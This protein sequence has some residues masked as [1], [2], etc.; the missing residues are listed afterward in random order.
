[1]LDIDEMLKDVVSRVNTETGMDL[2]FQLKRHS[3]SVTSEIYT[4][5]TDEK[6]RV[7]NRAMGEYEIYSIPLPID[8]S[9]SYQD[10]ISKYLSL[11]IER[12]LGS[13]SNKSRV[14]IVGLG[15]RHISSDSLGAKVCGKIGITIDNNN[16]PK[17]MAICP[18]VLGLTGIETYDII[19]GVIE[20]VKP[21]HLILIDS[22]CAS[23]V[24]RLGTSIQLS[25]TGLCPGRGIGNNR[26]CI[27]KSLCKN[28]VSIGVPL[29]IFASTFIRD[30]FNKNNIDFD[31]VADIMQNNEIVSNNE[32]FLKFFESI[33]SVYNDD[34]DGAIVTHKDIDK[35]VVNLAEIIAMAINKSLGV[36]ELIDG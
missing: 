31:V 19:S 17:V 22:L 26:R 15:N 13:I 32:D 14:L 2:P 4:I 23:S 30:T 25:N 35:M 20:K 3:E 21:T 11:S 27:D 18:S 16:L 10:K 5:D 6:S 1:M 34:I 9:K 28:I 12:M 33:K 7:Y 29:L 24:D 8:L 36:L